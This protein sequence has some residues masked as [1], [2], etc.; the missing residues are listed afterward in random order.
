MIIKRFILLLYILFF[1]AS[2]LADGVHY[3]TLS[4]HPFSLSESGIGALGDE[5]YVCLCN[6]STEAADLAT[7]TIQIANDVT[8]SIAEGRQITPSQSYNLKLGGAWSTGELC[9]SKLSNI[10]VNGFASSV[11]TGESADL[12]MGIINKADSE[13]QEATWSASAGLISYSHTV[14]SSGVDVE[15]YNRYGVCDYSNVMESYYMALSVCGDHPI[16]G[17]RLS[18]PRTNAA[19]NYTFNFT[20]SGALD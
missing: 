11:A 1:S 4:M 9:A 19:Q 12:W 3:Y 10:K 14:T 6:A 8:S 5:A 7:I 17:L 13:C 2:I 20:V 18:S 16:L 15:S